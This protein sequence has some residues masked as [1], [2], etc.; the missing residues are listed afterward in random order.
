M[1]GRSPLRSAPASNESRARA[2]RSDVLAGELAPGGGEMAC[3]KCASSADVVGGVVDDGPATSSS[4]RTALL[5]C[6]RPDGTSPVNLASSLAN[7][8]SSSLAS[9]MARCASCSASLSASRC[10]LSSSGSQ[11]GGPG[12]GFLPSLIALLISAAFHFAY[13]RFSMT[14]SDAPPKMSSSSRKLDAARNLRAVLR[15]ALPPLSSLS[16]PTKTLRAKFSMYAEPASFDVAA[17]FSERD[18]L[19]CVMGGVNIGGG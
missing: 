11:P 15:S 3:A 9:A 17:S 12:A 7:K 5:C 2:L 6:G 18:C 16:A 1:G 4:P 8:S 13:L 14:S 10:L 19:S